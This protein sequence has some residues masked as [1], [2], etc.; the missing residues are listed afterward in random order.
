MLETR[1][2]FIMLARCA[3][4]V[5]TLI[6]SLVPI[7]LF[8]NPAQINSRISCSREVS[9]SGRFLRGGGSRSARDLRTRGLLVALAIIVSSPLNRRGLRYTRPALL[10]LR[11]NAGKSIE[12]FLMSVN[13]STMALVGLLSTETRVFVTS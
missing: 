9:D 8:L 4:T 12:I 13:A 11:R 2:F 1:I 3:S 6:L 7:S 10:R 5:F